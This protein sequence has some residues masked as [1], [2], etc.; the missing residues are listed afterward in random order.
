MW[1]M[2]GTRHINHHFNSRSTTMFRLV[3]NIDPAVEG[4][5]HIGTT[6]LSRALLLFLFLVR[7]AFRS[8]RSDP[9]T[10]IHF[11]FQTCACNP[12]SFLI[13][14]I[15]T[16]GQVKSN[17]RFHKGLV[18]GPLTSDNGTAN[19]TSILGVARHDV[20]KGP[21]KFHRGV[22]QEAQSQEMMTQRGQ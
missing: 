22:W 14:V 18:K 17:G 16:A 11:Y 6:N 10:I 8:V 12:A 19:A 5:R 20:A 9:I 13:L 4:L 1:P 15:A 2:I 21:K 3:Q 7:S